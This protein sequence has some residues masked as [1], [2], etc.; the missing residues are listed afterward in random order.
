MDGEASGLRQ[1]DADFK[2][3]AGTLTVTPTHAAWVPKQKDAMDRQNQALSRVITMLASKAGAVKTSLKL[4]FKDNLPAGGLTFTF[5]SANSVVDRQTVQDL[6]IPFVAANKA[7]PTASASAGPSTPTASTPTTAAA[8]TVLSANA[9]GKRK[10]D[11]PPPLAT[12]NGKAPRPLNVKLRLRVL[13]KNPTLKMLHRDLVIGKQITE[14]EFWDGREAMLLAEEMAYAQRP[15]RPSRLLDDRFDLDSGSKKAKDGQGGTGLGTKK[16]ESGPIVLNLSKEL[17]REI[18]EEFPVVQ[19]AYAKHVPGITEAEFWSR[20]FTSTLWE[21]HRASVRKSANDELSRKKDDIFDQYLE[22]PDWNLAPKRT[23]PNDVERYLDLAATEEDHG[24]AITIRDV[25]MQAGKER[26]SLPLIRR[27]NE[28][29]QKLL[30]AGR[31]SDT[32]PAT[33]RTISEDD[34]DIYGEIELDDLRGPAAPSTIPLDVQNASSLMDAQND[35]DDGSR[36]IL[37]GK[38]NG[39]LITIA[40]KQGRQIRSW[41]LDFSEVSIPTPPGGWASDRAA[42]EDADEQARQYEKYKIQRDTQAGAMQVVKDMH[43]AYNAENAQSEPLPQEILD[44]MRSCHN[45]ATEFLRQ[46]WSAILPSA[47]G[48]LGAG[49]ASYSLAAKS[50]KA[51][52][53]AKY[54]ALTEGK[55]NAV[56]H[57]ATIARVDPARVRAALAPTL[58][59]VNIAMA[60]ERKRVANGM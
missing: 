36:G 41:Q 39:E 16:V 8:A 27:F 47:P 1:Y 32:R 25:T 12:S 38:T 37:P 51:A 46:Y 24:E 58:G 2:K 34:L 44:Q 45:A 19:D 15:G 26:S 55:I 11:D 57:T 13:N 18:F 21:R 20:Y 54:L 6:L 7:A 9:K 4:V 43:L 17:T 33:S 49:S 3:V 59:A 30:M 14:E 50:A 10:A 35:E 23:Q 42:A 60:R 40:E 29:S 31:S 48:T 56:V 52:K 53:M 22:E 5:T 28:H